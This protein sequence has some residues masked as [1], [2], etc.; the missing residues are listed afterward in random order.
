MSSVQAPV[1][2]D[3]CVL[4]SRSDLARLTQAVHAVKNILP[5]VFDADFLTAYRNQQIL[6]EGCTCKF[7]LDN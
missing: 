2:G 3:D 7:H 1:V 6:E 5:H 4:I